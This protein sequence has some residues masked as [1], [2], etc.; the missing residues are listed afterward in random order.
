MIAVI[1]G[2]IILAILIIIGF[3]IL[4]N[5]KLKKL[6]HSLEDF[7]KE[8]ERLASA[9]E[10]L[11]ISNKHLED[12]VNSQ[13]AEITT[14]KEKRDQLISELSQLKQD[15]AVYRSI[16]ED[17]K[18]EYE[19]KVATL[20]S[21]IKRNQEE[22]AQEKEEN[23]KKEIARFESMK[24]TWAEHQEKVKNAIKMICERHTID[25]VEK[26]PFKGAPDN[27]IK[28]CDEFVI[29]DAKS[30]SS[31]DLGNFPTYIKAQTESVKKYIKEENVRK[32]IF[33]VI[34]SNTVDVIEKFSYPMGDYTVYIITLD[35]LEPIILNLKKIESYEFID[36][37]N[38][39]E[40]ENICAVIGR[41]AHMTKRRIQIDQFFAMEFLSVLT[42][43]GADLPEDILKKVI[44][45]EKEQKLNPPQDRV[46][47]QI[48]DTELRTKAEKIKREAEAKGIIFPSSVQKGL[49]GLP[50]YEGEE[51][52]ST[53]SKN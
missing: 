35:V 25:Y 38:P 16:E 31:D 36:Q 11:K 43:C 2:G 28:I 29:F 30:P 53:D 22:R 24:K 20:D 21:V 51:S 9:T 45:F 12:N 5:E 1:F 44:E 41:F 42:K 4:S 19:K 34:P 52:D 33:L 46:G 6:E 27:T 23:H 3:G 13:K 26:V 15:N 50:L 32:D 17:R 49:K 10:N 18:V 8:K 40:R 7:Q 37:L 48:P 39:E 14:L 47:K